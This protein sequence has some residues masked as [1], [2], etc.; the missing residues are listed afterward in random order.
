MIP[1]IFPDFSLCLPFRITYFK[2]IDYLNPYN[3]FIWLCVFI[4][5]DVSRQKED[6]ILE[7]LGTWLHL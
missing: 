6:D 5:E 4:K 7:S 3:V 2:Y 1:F